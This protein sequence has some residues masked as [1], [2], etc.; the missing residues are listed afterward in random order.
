MRQRLIDT[1]RRPA[2]PDEAALLETAGTKMY[3]AR[4]LR[5]SGCGLVV[6]S[7]RRQTHDFFDI[8]VIDAEL[9][10]DV[11]RPDL[12]AEVV[13]EI[14]LAADVGARRL[15]VLTHHHE[16]RKE[17]SFEA[18]NHREETERKLVE[19]EGTAQERG[20]SSGPSGY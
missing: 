15:A 19:D 18:D 20:G 7:L 10:A 14:E 1:L 9:R 13:L 3:P 4:R 8:I 17:D 11:N 16:C 6:R 2:R 5:D 12:G